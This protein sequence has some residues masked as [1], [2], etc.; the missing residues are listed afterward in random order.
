M[1]EGNAP[2][3]AAIWPAIVGVMSD[4]F[5]LP[6]DRQMPKEARVG[7]YAYRS[8]EQ[9]DAAMARA[10]RDHKIMLQSRDLHLE[11]EQTKLSRQGSDRVYTSVWVTVTYVFTSL[12]D[13]SVAEFASAGEGRSDDDKSTNKAMTAAKKNALTQAFQ[14]AYEGVEDTDGHRVLMEGDTPAPPVTTPAAETP[15][16]R[17][18]RE[19]FEARRAQASAPAAQAAPPTT[20]QPSAA[21]EHRMIGEVHPEALAAAMEQL[22]IARRQAADAEAGGESYQP[23]DAAQAKRCA[24]AV[25]AATGSPKAKIVQIVL[26]CAQEGLLP[27]T[28]QG[29]VLASQLSAV[30]AV[31]T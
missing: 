2:G 4:V 15:A 20:A 3:T 25:R 21:P 23:R 27:L 12:V 10:F 29:G 11:H 19:A 16:Q 24:D 18:A 17:A 1:T 22:A 31:A 28:T 8:A 5:G 9:V 30:L 6:K 7:E 14:V 26:T 13:G